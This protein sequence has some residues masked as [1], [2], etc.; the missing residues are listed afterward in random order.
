MSLTVFGP[1]YATY[2][3]YVANTEAPSLKIKS[4]WDDSPSDYVFDYPSTARSTFI[5]DIPLQN[6][7]DIQ[8]DVSIPAELSVQY[9][10]DSEP[11]LDGTSFTRDMGDFTPGSH[12][13]D[14][15]ILDPEGR[16]LYA[17]ND[18][19]S[20]DIKDS[21]PFDLRFAD[22]SGNPVDTENLRFLDD[23]NVGQ[24]TVEVVVPY[25]PI[26]AAYASWDFGLRLIQKSD[27]QQINTGVIFDRSSAAGTGKGTAQG[28]LNPGSLFND[29][30]KGE[31]GVDYDARLFARRVVNGVPETTKSFTVKEPIFVAS[32]PDWVDA[33]PEEVTYEETDAFGGQQRAYVIPA[34]GGIQLNETFPTTHDTPLGIFDGLASS[35]QA[36]VNLMVY[37]LADVRQKPILRAEEWRAKATLLGKTLVDSHGDTADL[38]PDVIVEAYL[39]PKL[40]GL[41]NG[42]TLSMPAVEVF[43][44][45]TNDKFQLFDVSLPIYHIGVAGVY[46][47][48]KAEGQF[49]LGG[50]LTLAAQLQLKEVGGE[51]AFV[52]DGSFVRLDVESKMK[53]DLEGEGSLSVKATVSAPNVPN[54]SPEEKDELDKIKSLEVDLIT[55]IGKATA[56]AVL[57]G[58][59]QANFSGSL[60]SQV[61]FRDSSLG[62][63]GSITYA[64]DWCTFF[65][66][67]EL[68]DKQVI[69]W[70]PFILIGD[71]A[72]YLDPNIPQSSTTSGAGI[73]GSTAGAGASVANLD[74]AKQ[75]TTGGSAAA[76]PPL[77]GGMAAGMAGSEWRG[78]MQFKEPFD[79]RLYQVDYSFE[80]T[81]ST[82]TRARAALPRDRVGQWRHRDCARVHRPR[83]AHVCGSGSSWSV[84][85]GDRGTYCAHSGRVVG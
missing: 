32:L 71:P 59:V 69:S 15:Q 12:Y 49:K 9:R 74:A 79:S 75:G 60:P 58:K 27:G 62:L 6:Q 24:W 7:F 21:I 39:E 85:H 36:S 48:V 80:A 84:R 31:S 4:Q 83:R 28:V 44:Q 61:D 47:N 45:S 77:A 41:P 22:A 66:K 3:L 67:C 46:A 78:A 18:R 14:V 81:S 76:G 54:L 68:D 53:L 50:K 10:I 37:A 82:A 23:V 34:K 64:W 38:F 29:L 72:L 63:R 25:V 1:S 11:W 17:Y 20:I 56:E 30:V 33:T 55:A 13:I 8:F 70:G 51:L 42:V 57:L 2:K 40:L 19:N 65:T 43:A 16:L 35:L 52:Q 5:Y 26:P 73:S